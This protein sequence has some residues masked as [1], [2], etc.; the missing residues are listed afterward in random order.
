M[1]AAMEPEALR[2]AGKFLIRHITSIKALLGGDLTS[3][4]MQF[5]AIEKIGYHATF[6]QV[7]EVVMLEL[8]AAAIS[9][10]D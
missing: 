6:E 10:A 7:C 8:D 3:L 2:Q 1:V 5:D 4:R 9:V